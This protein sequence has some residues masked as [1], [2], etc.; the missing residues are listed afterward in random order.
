ME[1]FLWKNYRKITELQVKQNIT[2]YLKNEEGNFEMYV[3]VIVLFQRQRG[4]DFREKDL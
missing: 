4:F 1:R 3:F 2:K